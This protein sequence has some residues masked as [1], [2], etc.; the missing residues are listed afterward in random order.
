MCRNGAGREGT[1]ENCGDRPGRL[2]NTEEEQEFKLW[3][4]EGGKARQDTG[5]ENHGRLFI[6]WERWW[7]LFF[8]GLNVPAACSTDFVGVD[9]RQE[10]RGR[11]RKS[12]KLEWT[13]DLAGE[14]PGW[15]PSLYL[16]I[17]P[18]FVLQAQIDN[19]LFHRSAWILNAHLTNSRKQKTWFCPPNWFFPWLSTFQQN[20]S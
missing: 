1:P 12:S 10:A 4:G 11:L 8:K 13:P 17:C 14:V 3:A 5:G 19:C 18:F 15:C 16:Q 2:K 6:Q 9:W 20:T 7:E